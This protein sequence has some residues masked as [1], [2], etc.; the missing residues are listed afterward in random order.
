MT[1]AEMNTTPIVGEITA[2]EI[3]NALLKPREF[4]L[5]RPCGGSF[6]LDGV[7]ALASDIFPPFQLVKWSDR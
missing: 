3:A 4:A 6:P 1:S 2:T 5:R 7:D